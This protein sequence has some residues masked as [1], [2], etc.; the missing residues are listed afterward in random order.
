M[1]GGLCKWDGVSV[2][3]ELRDVLLSGIK[4]NIVRELDPIDHAELVKKLQED[5][6]R[7]KQEE[8]RSVKVRERGGGWV[9]LKE[10][11]VYYVHVAFHSIY[12]C[13]MYLQG[14]HKNK[15]TLIN[16]SQ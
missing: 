8:N 3:E 9:N 16:I 15:F 1:I 2:Y 14:A 11:N 4:N 12:L 13:T 7:E 5:N 10:G 6:T